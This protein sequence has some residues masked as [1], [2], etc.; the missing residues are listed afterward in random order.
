MKTI[1]FQWW[2]GDTR[3]I[4]IKLGHKDVQH[5]FGYGHCHSFA[6]AVIELTGWKLCGIDWYGEDD[7]RYT[8]EYP[9]HF[10]VETPEGRYMDINGVFTKRGLNQFYNGTAEDLS[11]A[12]VK[13]TRYGGYLRAEVENALPFARLAVAQY[14]R[15]PK[16]KR[17][18]IRFSK[19]QR[20]NFNT[21][22]RKPKYKEV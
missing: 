16:E 11:Y 1:T 12:Q 21:K 15:M 7:S 14:K 20:Y 8:G 3:T 18:S 17:R 9:D 6:L 4:P 19:N 10:V 22:P 5:T 2:A 13:A